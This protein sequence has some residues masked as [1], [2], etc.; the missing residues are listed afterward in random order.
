MN[1]ILTLPDFSIGW[2]KC[3]L[4]GLQ[5][6]RMCTRRIKTNVG[7]L[8][9]LTVRAA[10]AVLRENGYDQIAAIDPINKYNF[11]IFSFLTTE[12]RPYLLVDR[13]KKVATVAV[14]FFEQKLEPTQTFFF[15]FGMLKGTKISAMVDTLERNPN[16]PLHQFHAER[17]DNLLNK[18]HESKI[19]KLA[20]QASI[21]ANL[22]ADFRVHAQNELDQWNALD[23][24]D[25]E[26]KKAY[27]EIAAPFCLDE[28]GSCNFTMKM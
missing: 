3:N 16:S 14:G 20:L 10:R 9:R 5:E 1:P 26:L 15:Y 4:T 17:L 2:S 6:H 28:L 13:S 8:G 22:S 25:Q 24:S 27:R 12:G 21:D 7:K 11:F 19:K 18:C 23:K